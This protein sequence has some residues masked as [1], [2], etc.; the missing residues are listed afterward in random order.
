MNSLFKDK[1]VSLRCHL[2]LAVLVLPY[3]LLYEKGVSLRFINSHFTPEL[4]IIMYHITRL[5]ELAYIIFVIILGLFTEKR[6]FLTI[7]VAM[8]ISGLLIFLFKHHLFADFNRPYF[9]LNSEKIPFHHVQG[10]RLHSN[11]SFPSGHTMAAFSSLALIGFVS[12]SGW[13]QFGL[14]LLA[15][16]SGYSRVYVAQHYLMD[17]Y[18]GALIG[19][20]IALFCYI[21]FH[22][23][24]KTP[25]WM[26][27]IIQFKS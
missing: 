27:P 9:W 6:M 21:L 18:A 12:R 25:F 3:V 1:K 13:T 4:D 11:N 26:S 17:V 23:M 2:V 8:G 19:F 5:P 20:A 7:I 16:V 10:I 24:F 14:F 15:C 22:S